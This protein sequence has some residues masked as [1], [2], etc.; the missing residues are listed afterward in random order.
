MSNINIACVIDDDPIHVFGVKH[1]LES[2]NL[3]GKTIYYTN[4]KEAYEG[5]KAIW[6]EGKELPELILLDINMP[7]WDG[8]D[9]LDEFTKLPISKKVI[10]YIVTSSIDPE[11]KEKAASYNELSDFVVKP[12]SLDTLREIIT[13][14][15]ADVQRELRS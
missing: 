8:W 7:V 10:I 9:F 1:L 6:D 15:L 14:G 11:D 3:S 12:I 13:K 4:G 2:S 5:L